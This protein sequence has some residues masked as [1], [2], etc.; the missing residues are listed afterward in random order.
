MSCL[1]IVELIYSCWLRHNE[2]SSSTRHAQTIVYLKRLVHWSYVN[3]ASGGRIEWRRCLGNALVLS[4]LDLPTPADNITNFHPATIM[5][6]LYPSNHQKPM[7]A[8]PIPSAAIP[9]PGPGASGFYSHIQPLLE[10]LLPVM[11]GIAPASAARQ[12]VLEKIL[13]PLHRPNDM[14]LWRDQVPVLQDYHEM[15]VRCTVKT[16]MYVCMYVCMNE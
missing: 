9:G 13:L 10:L 1:V 11:D 6:K 16:A 4:P 12:Q 3:S 2:V 7:R 14:V 8:R 15:L 5:A